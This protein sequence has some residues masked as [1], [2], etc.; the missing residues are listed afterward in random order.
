MESCA[1][2]DL[3]LTTEQSAKIWSFRETHLKEVMPLRNQLFS[4]RAELRLLWV[5][6]KTDKNKIISKQK[7]ISNL[8]Y[9]IREKKTN[10]R[11]EI[12]K[13]LTPEQQGK[14]MLSRGGKNHK[15]Q[16]GTGRNQHNRKGS[17]GWR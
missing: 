13:V 7:E 15:H 10:Y 1:I 4:K 8:Q 6:I 2:L 11:L 5:Q 9:Q 12:R 14:L 17:A 3:N 16:A